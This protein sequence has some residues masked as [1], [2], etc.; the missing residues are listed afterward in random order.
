MATPG[1]YFGRDRFGILFGPNSSIPTITDGDGVTTGGA[2]YYY[3][4]SN[5]NLD[6][7]TLRT[8]SQSQKP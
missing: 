3:F 8:I 7:N 2:S 4:T 1:S 5:Q 6:V